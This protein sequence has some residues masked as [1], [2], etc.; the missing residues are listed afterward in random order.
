VISTNEELRTLFNTAKAAMKY[1]TE[2]DRSN[3]EMTLSSVRTLV[4]CMGVLSDLQAMLESGTT[5]TEAAQML[6]QRLFWDECADHQGAIVATNC[7]GP[8]L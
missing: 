3:D 2:L 1:R 8:R 6:G 4:A 7:F 5:T